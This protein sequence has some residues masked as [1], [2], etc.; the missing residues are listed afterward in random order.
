MV[1]FYLGYVPKNKK[2]IRLKPERNWKEQLFN[3]F[4]IV[5]INELLWEKVQ[6]LFKI[7]KRGYDAHI[8]I[9]GKRRTG[10]ST[11]AKTIAY[12]KK[13][14]LSINN[15]VVGLQDAPKC[16]AK[17]KDEDPLIFDEATL[18]FNSRDGMKGGQSNLLQII[19]VVGQK[20][21]LCIYCIPNFLHL[22]KTIAIEHSLFLIQTYTDDNLVRGNFAYFSTEQ[23]RYLY[24]AGKKDYRSL[25]K[26][27]AQF[28][29]RF[30][31]FKVPF[32]AE[33]DKLKM[34]SLKEA[35]GQKD[36][37]KINQEERKKF[38]QLSINNLHKSSI[39]LT[40]TQM[41][42]VFGVSSRSIDNYKR[43]LKEFNA[44]ESTQI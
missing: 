23:K 24:E 28:T 42:V 20:R 29:G 21:L 2:W 3:G 1:D 10:K 37:F 12:L 26:S 33:Y 34:S 44:N 16:I 15:F 25:N 43:E 17:A 8:V 22:N 31:D 14:T 38:I 36:I 41:A 32:E 5:K 30:A 35:L 4:K 27:E 18:S 39:K 40:N 7:Q 19:D 13:P 9:G 11:L 6:N